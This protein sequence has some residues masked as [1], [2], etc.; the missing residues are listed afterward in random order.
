MKR[1]ECS[2]VPIATMPHLERSG[3]ELDGIHPSFTPPDDEALEDT[4]NDVDDCVFRYGLELAERLRQ[5]TASHGQKRRT[6]DTTTATVSSMS[7]IGGRPTTL[8]Q[9][10]RQPLRTLKRPRR[11]EQPCRCEGPRSR[12]RPLPHE[13][14]GLRQE[15][16]LLLRS[17]RPLSDLTW[18]R[19][20]NRLA[21]LRRR[22]A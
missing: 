5:D 10:L 18:L 2:E 8:Q 17:L 16:L 9:P 6:A 19:S 12:P 21:L 22:S 14:S 20:S 11:P 7:G 4:Q 13:D 3:E 15:S 1:R